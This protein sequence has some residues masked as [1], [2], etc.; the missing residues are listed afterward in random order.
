[1]GKAIEQ[2][3]VWFVILTGIS[4]V[5]GVFNI[6]MMNSHAEKYCYIIVDMIEESNG[7]NQSLQSEIDSIAIEHG[8]VIVVT[9]IKVK[10]NVK[11]NVYVESTFIFIDKVNVI[12]VK[13]NKR[14]KLLTS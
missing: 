3:L 4:L 1:M 9:P 6:V 7:L 13:E 2:I 5:L 12:T 14:T 10:N 8:L 11:Y